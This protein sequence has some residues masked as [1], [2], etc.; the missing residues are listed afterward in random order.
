VS[1]I[2]FTPTNR[3]VAAMQPHEL[4]V[5]HHIVIER[6]GCWPRFNE[7]EVHRLVLD[8]SHRSTGGS[9]IPTLELVVRGWNTALDGESGLL[10]I[11]DDTLVHFLF[12]EVSDVELD[13]FN[14]QNV[15]DSLEFMLVQASENRACLK[16]ELA[17][18]FG[19]AGGF[20]AVSGRVLA[21]TPFGAQCRS[22]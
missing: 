18:C 1:P 17:H 2:P 15:L 12:E 22:Q 10:I 4:I 21:A 9:Y 3:E 14:Q 16:V 13:G 5:D 6:F 20:T 19:L 7:G 8:R 11:K